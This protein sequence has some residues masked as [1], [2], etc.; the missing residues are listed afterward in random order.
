MYNGKLLQTE[1][2][3]KMHSFCL[4]FIKQS[5]AENDAEHIVVVTHHLPHCGNV[6]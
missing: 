6:K 5:L 2:F 4:N 3:N 1:E